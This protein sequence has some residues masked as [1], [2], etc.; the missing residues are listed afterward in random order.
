M[1]N[2]PSEGSF[3]QSHNSKITLLK[4]F[5]IWVLLPIAF[6]TMLEIWL[7]GKE[8]L[9][10]LHPASLAILAAI[11]LYIPIIVALKLNQGASVLSKFV[12]ALIFTLI[13]YTVLIVV[14]F[15]AVAFYEHHLL[16][17]LE[18]ASGISKTLLG[19][20]VYEN[21]SLRYK[22]SYPKDYV[23][24]TK[25]DA[26]KNTTIAP[27][28]EST[29]VFVAKNNDILF[30]C[31][32]VTLRFKAGMTTADLREALQ[33]YI[34]DSH[35]DMTDKI[36]PIII[37]GKS[38]FVINGS[39]S[40]NSPYRIIVLSIGRTTPLLIEQGMADEQLNSIVEKISFE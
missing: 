8:S 14:F 12:K 11:V 27:N 6:V 33:R 1:Q 20:N 35:Y 23:V 9:G 13:G 18:P 40:I 30:C 17:N 25:V 22:I 37:N 4:R 28:S 10:I 2:I 7:V 24:F 36:Q 39:G 29:E 38:G 3:Q 21:K 15:S 5:I 16:K 32:A 26:S 19:D 31:E 34:T